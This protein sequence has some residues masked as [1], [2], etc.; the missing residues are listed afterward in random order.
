YLEGLPIYSATGNVTGSVP[1]VLKIT[2]DF[3]P[4]QETSTIQYRANLA[5]TPTTQQS[6]TGGSELLSATGWAA[7]GDPTVAGDGVVLG[8]NKQTFENQTIAGGAVTIF[9]AQGSPVNVQIRWAKLDSIAAGGTDTWE[10]FYQ[11]NTNPAAADTAWTNA[12]TTFTFDANGQMSPQVSSLTLT[13]V[14]VD[15]HVVGDVGVNFGANGMTQFADTN[16]VAQV[17]TIN[18]NGFAAGQLNSISVTN[19]GR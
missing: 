1:Q 3:L 12:G 8:S 7:N 5:A 9:D 13:G 17:N 4:A 10:M 11:T 15:G 19:K 18:Q 16:G 2:N 14:E 6:G